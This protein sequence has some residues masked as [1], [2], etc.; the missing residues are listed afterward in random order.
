MGI[1][2]FI[3]LLIGFALSLAASARS[4]E[5]VNIDSLSRAQMEHRQGYQFHIQ[6]DYDTALIWYEKAAATGLAKSELG[7]ARILAFDREGQ[8]EFAKALPY[9]IRAAAPRP[10]GHAQGY[11]FGE[12]QR[13]ATEALDWYCNNGPVE[14]PASHPSA[15]DPKC[16]Y[17]RGKALM[18]GWHDIKKDN[19]AARIWLVKAVEAE[20]EE[21]NATL[22]RLDKRIAK[23]PRKIKRPSAGHLFFIGFICL[24]LALIIRTQRARQLVYSLLYKFSA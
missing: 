9:Y 8:R 13:Q 19:D 16:W 14:F 23:A 2:V 12:A 15:Q 7:V 24:A 18:F 6:K 20:Y 11:G 5:L 21:A 3:Y 10:D 17:G 4:P 22:Q 1:K